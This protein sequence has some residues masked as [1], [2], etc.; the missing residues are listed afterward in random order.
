MS[1]LSI[2]VAR[3]KVFQMDKLFVPVNVSNAHWCMA[4]IYM[5]KKVRLDDHA[6][7]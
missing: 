6:T 3:I 2:F 4:I 7:A 5:Q 1:D